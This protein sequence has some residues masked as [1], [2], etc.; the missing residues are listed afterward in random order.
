MMAL[1]NF[2]SEMERE[3][4][5]QR[6]HDALARKARQGYV[7][8]G[9][10][11]GYRNVPIMDGER[12]ARVERVI[13][14]DE[15]DVIRRIFRLVAQGEGYKRVAAALN[16][17]GALAPVPR[18]AHRPRGWAPSSVREIVFRELYRGAIVWNQ[19]QKIV[20]QGAKKVRR[21]A[22]SD[23]LRVDAPTFRIVSED[24]WRAAHERIDASR[25]LYF[26]VTDGPGGAPGQWDRIALPPDRAPVVRRLW[27]WSFRS[28][29]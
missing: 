2:A 25:A 16:A 6:T 5:G 26:K 3:K 7:T 24:L 10:V 15:A 22:E 18:P 27:C 29:P 12:R 20:R 13:H 23:W 14:D 19:R 8:G 4:A 9:C 28:Q 1:S 11:F 17:E 21:R